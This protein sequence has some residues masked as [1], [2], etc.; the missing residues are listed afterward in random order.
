MFRRLEKDVGR[1][2]ARRPLGI[3]SLALTHVSV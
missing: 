3:I 1:R 2:H